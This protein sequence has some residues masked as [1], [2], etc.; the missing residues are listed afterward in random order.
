MGIID[1]HKKND[2]EHHAPCRKPKTEKQ[3]LKTP[4]QSQPKPNQPTAFIF[5][6]NR[7]SQPRSE[8]TSKKY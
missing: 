7:A 5:D 8:E 2:P 1:T 3:S 4:C 6:P